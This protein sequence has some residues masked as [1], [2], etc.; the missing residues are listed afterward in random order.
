SLL[1]RCEITLPAFSEGGTGFPLQGIPLLT[2]LT[3]TTRKINSFK[4]GNEVPFFK[5]SSLLKGGYLVF[6]RTHMKNKLVTGAHC[7]SPWHHMRIVS[8]NDNAGR[9]T[10][11]HTG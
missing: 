10:R 3:V 2:G 5:K 4:E 1:S 8:R 11:T 7:L 6:E 9:G